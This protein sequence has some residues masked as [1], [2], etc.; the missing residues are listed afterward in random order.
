MEENMKVIPGE[1]ECQLASLYSFKR[2]LCRDALYLTVRLGQPLGKAE[3]LV[4]IVVVVLTF[5]N[6]DW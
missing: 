4:V 5:T 1:C 3:Q 6:C 2:S